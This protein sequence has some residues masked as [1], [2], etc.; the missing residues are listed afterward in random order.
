MKAGLRAQ[1][2]AS[3]CPKTMDQT[4]NYENNGEDCKMK[5]ENNDI[6]VSVIDAI[7][8]IKMAFINIIEV[9][10]WHFI[11]QILMK[12]RKQI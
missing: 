4:E 6:S 2:K 3:V 9:L 11:M 8:C 12:L 10:N 1:L 7:L 5:S